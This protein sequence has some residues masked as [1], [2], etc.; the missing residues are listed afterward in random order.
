MYLLN[1]SIRLVQSLTKTQKLTMYSDSFVCFPSQQIQFQIK[2]R[3]SFFTKHLFILSPKLTKYTQ[4]MSS[5]CF[6]R[7]NL[8]IADQPVIK[9]DLHF[10]LLFR[11]TSLIFVGSK[12]LR[13]KYIIG[14]CCCW[15]YFFCLRR[16]SSSIRVRLS[17]IRLR[18]N[19]H[20]K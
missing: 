17:F 6:H 2:L 13:K 9:I 16:L 1:A 10:H 19:R 4:K 20:W 11:G 14:I 12:T 8:T 15:R 18:K 3:L 5:S 7:I